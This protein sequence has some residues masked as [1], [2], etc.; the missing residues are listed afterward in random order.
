[1]PYLL[2]SPLSVCRRY[3]PLGQDVP[4]SNYNR[5]NARMGA[6]ACLTLAGWGWT[7][8]LCTTASLPSDCVRH[9]PGGSGVLETL[10][11]VQ[12]MLTFCFVQ[13]ESIYM[14]KRA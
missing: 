9:K 7:R 3:A 2:A 4:R 1:M 8:F 6:W 5:G 10:S 13:G 12:V 14:R 11:D